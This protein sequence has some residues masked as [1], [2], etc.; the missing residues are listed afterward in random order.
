MIHHLLHV[1]KRRDLKRYDLSIAELLIVSHSLFEG[2]QGTTFL[3]I[4]LSEV[5]QE[6][7]EL[8][9]CDKARAIDI[10]LRPDPLEVL[11]GFSLDGHVGK[12]SLTEEGIDDD[13]N[14]EV[15]EDL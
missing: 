12:L 9:D 15:E 14:E 1:A 6:F 7:I 5:N 2:N 8:A 13:G 4:G 10:V 3:R 11:N